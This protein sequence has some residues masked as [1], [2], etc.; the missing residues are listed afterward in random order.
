VSEQ[1]KALLGTDDGFL[2]GAA[3]VGT[4]P[5]CGRRRGAIS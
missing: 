1:S 4:A 5:L 2:L 3:I